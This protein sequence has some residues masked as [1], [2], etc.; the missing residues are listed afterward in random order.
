MDVS[1]AGVAM[2][3]MHAWFLQRLE[4]SVRAPR[5]GVTEGCK[6]LCGCWKYNLALLT[7]RESSQLLNH[8]STLIGASSKS[9]LGQVGSDFI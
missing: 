1:T 6:L 9:Q 2:H 3:C 5:A 8:L 4:E 7:N